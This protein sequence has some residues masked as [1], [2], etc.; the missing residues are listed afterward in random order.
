MRKVTG[1]KKLSIKEHF[2]RMLITLGWATTVSAITL[3]IYWM[4]KVTSF[5]GG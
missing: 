2:S 1:E 4:C 3:V 5:S